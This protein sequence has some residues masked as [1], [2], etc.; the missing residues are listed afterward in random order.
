MLGSLGL[1]RR[2]REFGLLFLATL[3]S[4]VGTYFAAIALAWHIYDLTGSGTWLSALLIVDFL[5]VIVIGLTLGPLVDRLSRRGL[6]IAADLVRAAVFCVLPF[7]ESPAAIVAL[8]AVTGVAMGFFRPAVYAGLPNLVRDEDLPAANSLLTAVENLAWMIGPVLGGILL[9]ASGPDL[10]YW[11]NAVTFV[12]SAALLARIP[13]SRLR[14]QEPLTRGHWTDV[15]DGLR[16][17]RSSHTLLTVLVVWNVVIAGTAGINVAEV[18]LARESLDAGSVGLGVLVGASGLGL[19]VGSLVAGEALE[20]LGVRR[21]YTVAIG[22]MA[23]GFGA[24]ALS[25]TILVASA[26][27]VV[28]TLGN[29]A[30]LVCNALLVQRGAPDRLRGRAF[31]VIMGSTYAVLG[32]AMAVAGPLTDAF[33]PRWIWGGAAIVFALGAVLAAALTREPTA[34]EAVEPEQLDAPA[35]RVRAAAG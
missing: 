14:S 17:I 22:L 30:A 13:A 8:A 3:G 33:G 20:R 11:V 4:G 1:V 23:I 10:A 31:T 32:I 18:V 28:A 15:A 2:S 21:L 27:V 9:A 34:A 29:G 26:F 6:M 19:T 7:V 12:A 35:R 24:A 25:P 16:L 5:P